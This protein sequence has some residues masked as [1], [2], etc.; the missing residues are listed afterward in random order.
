LTH[1][2]VDKANKTAESTWPEAELKGL[3]ENINSQTYKRQIQSL[4]IDELWNK[5]FRFKTFTLI[6]EGVKRI[7]PMYISLIK[8]IG[9]ILLHN[10]LVLET[11]FRLC[12]SSGLFWYAMLRFF[13]FSASALN[14]SVDLL[15]CNQKYIGLEWKDWV[16]FVEMRYILN[17][18]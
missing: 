4:G 13:L 2:T 12:I 5:C 6:A 7:C 18:V 3:L 14:S 17:W 1:K 10:Q 9:N 16:Y 8:K 15:E 11:M